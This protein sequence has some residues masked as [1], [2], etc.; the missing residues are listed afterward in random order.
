MRETL[1]A[2]IT[3]KTK[4]VYQEHYKVDRFVTGTRNAR[5]QQQAA[6]EMKNP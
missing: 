2:N 3:D 6:V 4:D 5:L 1:L